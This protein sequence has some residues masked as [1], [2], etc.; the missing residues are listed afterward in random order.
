M[1]IITMLKKPKPKYHNLMKKIILLLSLLGKIKSDESPPTGLVTDKAM[2][3]SARQ[4]ASTIGVAIMK[5]G[6]NALTMVATLALAV[7]HPGGIGGGGFMVFRKPMAK[8]SPDYRESVS[9]RSRK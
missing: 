1:P 8:R 9:R 3:V 6:G 7:S 4:E 5:K 2:V